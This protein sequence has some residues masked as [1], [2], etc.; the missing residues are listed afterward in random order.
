MYIRTYRLRKM[1][2]DKCLTC[3]ISEDPSTSNMVNRPKQCSKLN[4]SIF[5]IFTDLCE[6]NSG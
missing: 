2:L 5:T 1:W 6:D 3:P 4:E